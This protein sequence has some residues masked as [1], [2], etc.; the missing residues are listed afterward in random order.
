MQ[1]GAPLTKTS[2]VSQGPAESTA[3]TPDLSSWDS[4][5]NRLRTVRVVMQADRWPLNMRGSATV[6]L[7]CS[8]TQ[9]EK[10]TR[11]VPLCF[12]PAAQHSWEKVTRQ[13]HCVSL[14]QHNPVEG[15]QD[16]AT[17]FLS[18]ST[19][20]LKGHKRSATV[21]LFCSTTQLDKVRR[22]VP[23]CSSPAAQPS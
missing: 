22:G 1:A 6:F 16:S 9:L 23:L 13:C 21:F 19:T 4:N 14:L 8:T 3:R 20:Q 10:V 11:G 12:S 15:S 18:C 2:A 17:V 7:S 5:S